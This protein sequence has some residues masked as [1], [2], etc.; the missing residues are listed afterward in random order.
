MQQLGNLK[1]K[2][3]LEICILRLG[4][5]VSGGAMNNSHLDLLASYHYCRHDNEVIRATTSLSVDL[6]V[7]FLPINSKE[8]EINKFT[9]RLLRAQQ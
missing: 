8:L 7:I 4:D 2:S 1:T 6:G 5:D 3:I 9:D